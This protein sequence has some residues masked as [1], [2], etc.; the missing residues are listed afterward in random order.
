MARSG[1]DVEQVEAA[2]RA[3]KT[4]ASALEGT[5][6]SLDSLVRTLP[7]VWEGQDAQMFVHQWW[8]EH[9]AKLVAAI[10]SVDGLGQS[11][12]N[13][14]SEQRQA[15]GGARRSSGAGTAAVAA[16]VAGGG[17][18][19]TTP[20]PQPASSATPI[21]GKGVN[22]AASHT[23]QEWLASHHGRNGHDTNGAAEGQCTSWAEYRS[24]Q[25]LGAGSGLSHPDAMK[26]DGGQMAAN[27]GGT[28]QTAPTVGA[29]ASYREGTNGHVM[30][31]ERVSTDASGHQVVDISEMNYGRNGSGLNTV[32]TRQFTQGSDGLWRDRPGG[33]ARA[34][35]IS[36]PR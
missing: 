35:E 24:R 20:A 6:K 13:N 25:I 12:L 33:T 19:A 4:Q 9:R 31:I 2:G 10:S 30:V 14:A 23:Y 27:L 16:V 28:T 34:L 8:P 3:L 7:G 26:G 11:A 32:H 1:M 22:E 18:A 21:V 36:P 5:L 29:V 15:S 17:A